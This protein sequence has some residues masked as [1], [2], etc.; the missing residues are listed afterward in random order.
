MWWV[1]WPSVD[2]APHSYCG[3]VTPHVVTTHQ[4]AAYSPCIVPEDR[5]RRH[6]CGEAYPFPGTA[7]GGGHTQIYLSYSF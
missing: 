5:T 6:A 4:G 2:N 7:H 1:P 3:G